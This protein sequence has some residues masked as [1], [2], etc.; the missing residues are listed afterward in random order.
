M[1][2]FRSNPEFRHDKKNATGILLVN[3][4]T[5]DEPTPSAIRRYLAEFLS[6]PRVIEIP[7]WL[8]KLILHGVI[9]RIRPA[10]ISHAYKAIWTE[11][12]SPLLQI[13][14][15][16]TRLVERQ[17]KSQTKGN[18]VVEFG[19]R[20]GNPSIA[21][22]LERLLEANIDRLVVLPLYPQYSATTTAS[23]FDA[24]AKEL[25]QWRRLPALRMITQYHD[26]PGYIDSLA[27]SV[28]NYRESQGD[29]DI[30]LFS[31]HG[32]PKRYL[33]AGD[34]YFCH[35]Q[36][37]ARLVAEKLGLAK[38]QWH[39][40]FQ[41]RVGREEW[42]K[43]YTDETLIELAKR[44]DTS[45]QIICPG[46]SA[47]CLETLEEID[48]QNRQL[49]MDNGGTEYGYIPA[50]NAESDHVEFL[51]QLII[52]EAGDWMNVTDDDSRLRAALARQLGAEV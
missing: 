9:L 48:M 41:S 49:F 19:M 4:G 37:T 40:S 29:A 2:R 28:K 1:I 42:L 34:P 43:P 24:I 12:G 32:L 47:D 51:G 45:V 6:D 15:E 16:Q 14:R 30:L 23:S 25:M 39:I 21:S 7:R 27:N 22:A 11:H 13:T 36:K 8:W 46:F 18:V 26:H 3:L 50:L 10:R 31:F 44:K 52:H 17:L 35:C 38:S 5:P 20:Y 33:L